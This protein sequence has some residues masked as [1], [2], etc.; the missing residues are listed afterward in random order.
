MDINGNY[1]PVTAPMFFD[2]RKQSLEMQSLEPIKALE[3]MRGNIFTAAN[4]LDSVVARLKNI[5]E[6]QTLFQ[7]VFSASNS[8]NADN[9]AKAIASFERSLIS[10]NS[11]YD[12]YIRGQTTAMTQTQIQGMNAFIQIGC[13]KCHS[14]P[15][16]S[17]YQL[18]ILSVPENSK[19][20]TDS[21]ANK[22]YAFRTPTLRNLSFT[23]PYMHNGTIQTLDQVMQFYDQLGNGRSQN[24]HIPNSN[25]DTKLSGINDNQRALIIEFLKALDDNSFDKTIPARVPSNLNPGGNIF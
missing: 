20:S 10:I 23:A 12:N 22:T 19:I 13:A 9:M 14:G 1:D 18:H 4:A 21:G 11:A 25:L 2:N 24:P 5:P 7:T 16:F 6:Y 3:E 15:M 8:I 17:D